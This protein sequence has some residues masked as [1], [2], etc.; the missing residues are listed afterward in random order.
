MIPEL[1]LGGKRAPVGKFR[2]KRRYFGQVQ[3]QAAAFELYAGPDAWWD[4][5][6]Y[7]ADWPG[8][9]NRQWK[10]RAA[11]LRALATVFRHAAGRAPLVG[12]PFQAWILLSGRD[13]GEDGVYLH[14]PNPNGTPFPVRLSATTTAGDSRLQTFFARLL[15]EFDLCVLRARSFDEFA[16]PPGER[17]TFF[18]YATEVGEPIGT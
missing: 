14:S 2:G 7:H 1:F 15:P 18:V 13:A 16:E 3:A 17:S 8:W 9:G 11:H 6:H 10:Y 12:R 4:L 5:W